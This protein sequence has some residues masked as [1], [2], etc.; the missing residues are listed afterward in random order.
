MVK[1]NFLAAG[2][3]EGTQI[4]ILDQGIE[5]ERVGLRTNA[6][7]QTLSP[8][9]DLKYRFAILDKDRQRIAFAIL[10]ALFVK[11]PI[12]VTFQLRYLIDIVFQ[13]N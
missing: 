12:K 4:K 7:Y 11:S 10:E 8:I 13:T 1:E 3:P 9:F 6:T 2:N 5:I